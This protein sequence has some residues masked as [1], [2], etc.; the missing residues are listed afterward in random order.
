MHKSRPHNLGLTGGTRAWLE[1]DREHDILAWGE[2]LR[3]SLVLEGGRH[4]HWITQPVWAELSFVLEGSRRTIERAQLTSGAHLIHPGAT[5][6]LPLAIGIPE[7]VP[8]QHRPE[9]RV[10]IHS[11]L[12][13]Q[14][15]SVSVRVA[16]PPRYVAIVWQ[17]MNLTG[18]SVRYW[19]LEQDGVVVAH[20]K[21][22]HPEA[23][24]ASARLE[25]CP[26]HLP[27][28]GRIVIPGESLRAPARRVGR[29]VLPPLSEDPVRL[30]EQLEQLLRTRGYRPR[31]ARSL[32]VPADLPAASGT[33]FPIPAQEG[34]AAPSD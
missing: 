24:F 33:E 21:A 10:F 7:G 15:L 27:W 13:S 19:L 20:L 17:L 26:P 22:A 9:L 31:S 32:P 29:I 23:W 4:P 2:E 3:G 11:G 18:T 28:D 25:L 16:P 1:L 30:R 14:Q 6:R 8:F 5:E 34:C 12:W